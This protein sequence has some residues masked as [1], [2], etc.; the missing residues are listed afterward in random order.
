M[1]PHLLGSQHEI[2]TLFLST[3]FNCSFF[4]AGCLYQDRERANGE[5]WN[6][7]SD[8][9]T[10]CV[11]Q[12]GSVRCERKRCPDSNFQC[13]HPVPSGTCCP[14]CDS[15][16]YEGVVHSNDS[17]NWLANSTPC[18]TCMCVNGVTTCS[19]VSC[20]SPCANLITMPGECC[21]V[22]ADCVFEG[23]EYAPGESFHPANDPC[24]VCSCEVRKITCPVLNCPYDDRFTPP[25]S[26]CPVCKGERSYYKLMTPMEVKSIVEDVLFP[27][28]SSKQVVLLIVNHSTVVPGSCCPR[29]L[30]RPA[31]CI[32]FGD[33]HYRTFDGRMFHFQG[34]CTYILAKDCKS[35]DFS[36]LVTN[37]DR[38]RKGVSW[39]KEV[40]VFISHVT[41]QLP[42][43][44]LEVSVPGSYEGHTCGLCGNF[45][46]YPQ[47]DFK[48]S[49]GQISTSESEFGNSWRVYINP[50]KS[51]GFQARKGANT[52]CKVL[53]SALFKPCHSVVPPEPWYGA[54]VYDQCACGANTDECLCDTLEAYA[55]QCREAGV[56]LQWRSAS[57]SVG[58]PVER[59]FVFDE[60]G[61]PCPVTCFNVDVPLGVIESHCFKPC[62]PGC[63]CPAGLV[64]H[65]NYCI[66]P[67]KCPKI[68]HGS[69]Q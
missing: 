33:P 15:C 54:C 50:C 14:E 16:L 9:C 21:P 30:S 47:D 41:V 2:K 34:T 31:T 19:E 1:H 5:T 42:R 13:L 44:H 10:V 32:A 40:T 35:E 18:T 3:A 6:D 25:D 62:I 60:C 55:S 68:I 26:C 17:S 8:P 51:A 23:R 69:P 11:C 65:N 53:K 66:Q 63:Q 24:Q 59:G 22:C 38:G 46:K 48:M 64:L 29:C 36:V 43:S 52:R 39:T 67:E 57:L 61:P 27:G 7:P 56:I 12:H 4:P 37:D 58:C 28:G 20:V 45:N 49:T